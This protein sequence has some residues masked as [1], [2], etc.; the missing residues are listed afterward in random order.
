MHVDASTLAGVVNSVGCRVESFP[1][2]YLGLPLSCFKLVFADFHFIIDKVDR[3]LAGWR[4]LLLS[5]AG[6]MVLIN[7]VLD[8]IPFYAMGALKLPPMVVRALDSLRH[9]FLWNAVE[10]ASGA[11]C[12]VAWACVCRAKEEGGLGVRDLATQNDVV[13]LKILHRLHSATPYRWAAWVWGT[14]DGRLLLDSWGSVLAGEHWACLHGLMPLYHSLSRVVVGDGRTTTFWED[15]WLP[16][17]PLWLAFPA[18][19]THTTCPEVSV[20]VVHDWGLDAV[21]VPRLSSV[22]ARERLLLLPMVGTTAM[23]VPDV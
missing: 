1:Q 9:A 6:R 4:A 11:Q 3:Y 2:T 12:L 20:F 8:A 5:P 13:L 18:L 17:G 19:A 14:L 21:L 23:A 22:A 10:C 15:N 7:A 16:C